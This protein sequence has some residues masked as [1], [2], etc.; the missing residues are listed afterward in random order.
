MTASSSPGPTR[1]QID[2]VKQNITQMAERPEYVVGFRRGEAE[3]GGSLHFVMLVA[4]WKRDVLAAIGD[5]RV[6]GA[7]RV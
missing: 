7:A 5:H 4:R 3:L 2:R 6:V 1:G